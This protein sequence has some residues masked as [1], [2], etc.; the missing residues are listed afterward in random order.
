MYLRLGF[1]L[2]LLLCSGM[3]KMTYRFL[4]LVDCFG[5]AILDDMCGSHLLCR[6]SS[7]VRVDFEGSIQ[8]ACA[9]RATFFLAWGGGGG[10]DSKCSRV[11]KIVLGNWVAQEY[12]TPDPC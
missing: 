1:G 8:T 5:A 3:L 11:L 4:P 7:T 6:T 12:D 9:P 2:T 10:A